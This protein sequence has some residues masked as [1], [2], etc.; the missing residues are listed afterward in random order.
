MEVEIGV[1]VVA[2]TNDYTRNCPAVS[3]WVTVYKNTTIRY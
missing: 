3:H 1:V 2:D